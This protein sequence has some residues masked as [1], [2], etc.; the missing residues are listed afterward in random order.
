M[1][2]HC[3]FQ[4]TETIHCVVALCVSED[5][6][7]SL[8]CCTVC[9]RRQ[10]RFIVLL[11]GVF[12]KTETVHCVVARCVS[13]DRDG[14]LCCCTVCFRRQRQTE[15]MVLPRSVPSAVMVAT[16]I[17][18]SYT[19]QHAQCVPLGSFPVW[20]PKADL[21]LFLPVTVGQLVRFP[22]KNSLIQRLR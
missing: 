17:L 19:G 4:K 10:R 15:R 12:Q 11:H 18:L 22:S 5:R 3:V 14:S 8:C 20:G 1:L 21:N 9:F 7:G 6:D 16:V 2:L 13:E